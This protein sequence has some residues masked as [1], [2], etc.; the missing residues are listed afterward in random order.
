MLAGGN[1]GGPASAA[2]RDIMGGNDSKAVVERGKWMALTA[3]LLGWMFDGF[4]MGLFPVVS[5][6][7]LVELAKLQGV[8][9]GNTEALDNFRGF[10]NS[11]I[12]T[13]FL[14]GAATGGVLFG[15]LGDR[16]GRVRA[17]TL[18]ILTYAICSGLGG[19]AQAAWQMMLIRFIAA[20]GM[21]GEWSLGV[22]LVMEVW[23]GRSRELLAGVIGAAANLG[24]AL[25]ALLSLSLDSVQGHLSALGLPEPWVKW[26]LL[27]VCG[28][29]PA[30]LTFFIRLFVPES[31]SWERERE[32]GTTSS[33]ASRDL[34]SVLLG[35]GVCAGLIALWQ[36][37]N[38]LVA[39]STIKQGVGMEEQ[40]GFT[41]TVVVVVRT[42]GTL[43]AILLVAG[44]YLY[45]IYR[46]L[47]RAGEPAEVRRGIL[48]TMF[49]AAVISGVPLLATWGAVQWGPL[50]A[51]SLGEAAARQ[52]PALADS[53][54]YWKGWTQLLSSIGA[55]AGCVLG[56][57]FAGWAGRRIGYVAL[58]LTSL[59]SVLL[60]YQTNTSFG[61]WF[62]T[63]AFLAGAFSAAFYGWLPLYLPELFPTR[64]RATGQG[65]GFNFGRILAAIGVL[66]V[67]VLMG[68]PPDYARA[69]S[70]LALIYLAGLVVIWFAPE[71]KDRPL[72]E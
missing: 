66:Q 38:A 46:Y 58:C 39:P 43:A 70:L 30:L 6:P 21:G 56:T 50:W 54:K 4:E 10:W 9:I 48:R 64:V 42:V 28:A 27:M 45:P 1:N 24:Y 20:L 61:A 72:P 65:F 26:R 18:S 71:T 7:A 34:L 53:V 17:M 11:L 67:P 23:A 14:I 57:L 36:Y 41:T 68:R 13:S 40:A 51:S 52:N 33:W 16:L 44:C 19:L 29:L 22:A 5:G 32:R 12:N 35:V 15:W 3:A 59:G 49:L 55:I 31:A 62:L 69:C 47:G 2:R 60:F 8:D 63:T 37:T 25:V